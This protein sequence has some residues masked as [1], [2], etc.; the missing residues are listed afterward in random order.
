MMRHAVP[1][2]STAR[3]SGVLLS[4]VMPPGFS[5]LNLGL[6]LFGLFEANFTYLL[7]EHSDEILQ[8]CNYIL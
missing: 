3:R 8:L 7:G 5:A 4:V 1:L 6:L 2:R